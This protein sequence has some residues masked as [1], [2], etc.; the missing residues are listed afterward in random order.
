VTYNIQTEKNKMKLIKEY[1]NIIQKVSSN[2]PVLTTMM[3]GESMT[4]YLKLAFSKQS[5][6]SKS[7]V[8]TELN[9]KKIHLQI[10][11]SDVG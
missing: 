5:P 8:V 4:S 2:N 6:L 1:E 7:N 3:L 11:V 9:M 10:M